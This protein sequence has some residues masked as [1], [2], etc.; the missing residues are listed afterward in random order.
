MSTVRFGEFVSSLETK[1]TSSL[2]VTVWTG[3]T[4]QATVK[5]I[6]QRLNLSHSKVR[7]AHGQGM[8]ALR[9]EQDQIKDYLVS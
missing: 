7:S 3:G 6:A 5:Q 9:R 2:N 8:K 1:S 4:G